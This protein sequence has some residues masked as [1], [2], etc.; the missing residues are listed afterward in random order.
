MRATFLG[1]VSKFFYKGAGLIGTYRDGRQIGAIK[2]SIETLNHNVPVLIFPEQSDNGY[3]EV[4][5]DIHAGFVLLSKSYYHRYNEDLPVYPSY[6]CKKRRKIVIGKPLFVNK[7]LSSGHNK[8]SICQTVCDEVT[9]L[10]QNFGKD[11]V[12]LTISQ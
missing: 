12:P 11:G 2:R 3:S 5:Q 8:E 10:Y 4:P 7:M 1:I 9:R 6:Y